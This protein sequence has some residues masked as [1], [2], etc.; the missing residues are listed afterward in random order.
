M[1]SGVYSS[2]SLPYLVL[3]DVGRRIGDRVLFQHLSLSVPDDSIVVVAGPSG[4]GKTCLLRIVAGLDRDHWGRLILDGNDVTNRDPA[5]RG[6]SFLF[7]Q[8]VLYDHLSV[9]ENISF[10]HRIQKLPSEKSEKQVADLAERFEVAHLLDRSPKK[11]SGGETQRVALART[12]ASGRRVRLLDEPLKSALEPRLRRKLRSEIRSL[13][14]EVGG[15]TVLVTHDQ[16][17][18]LELADLLLVMLPECLAAGLEPSE[19]YRRPSSLELGQFIGGGAAFAG[20]LSG[21]RRRLITNQGVELALLGS[22]AEAQPATSWLVRPEALNLVEGSSFRVRS[23]LYRGADSYVEVEARNGDLTMEGRSSRIDY[24]S[25]D[26]VDVELDPSGILGFSESHELAER[27]DTSQTM[28]SKLQEAACCD[29]AFQYAQESLRT[30][31]REI[32]CSSGFVDELM[33]VLEILRSDSPSSGPRFLRAY[34]ELISRWNADLNSWYSIAYERHREDF[35][36][37]YLI[38]LVRSVGP[39]RI[40]DLGC[41]RGLVSQWLARSIPGA[42]VVGVDILSYPDWKSVMRANQSVRIEQVE[43]SDLAAWLSGEDA[44]DLAVCFWMFHHSE[45]REQWTTFAD[46]A[47]ALPKG[48]HLLVLEDAGVLASEPAADPNNFWPRFSE[49]RNLSVGGGMKD[50]TWAAQALLDFVAVRVLARYRSVDMPFEYRPGDMWID[51]AAQYCFRLVASRF[52]G[53]PSL[54]DIAVPQ[55]AGLFRSE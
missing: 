9:R 49:L 12:F 20:H 32:G 55:F 11:L 40:L 15:V 26:L 33:G 30:T 38:D 54:R 17:E 29:G 25:G 47:A 41:G 13:H 1:S 39:R 53:F 48:A 44:F 36:S 28:V 24:R 52:I 27:A 4:V 22:L 42:E 37:R 31:L 5:D 6:V 51:L 8:P 21:D 45:P 19:A 3:A 7:Q 16:E 46:L 23:V 10:P 2:S 50:G 35:F 34:E 18:A 14:R 43:V